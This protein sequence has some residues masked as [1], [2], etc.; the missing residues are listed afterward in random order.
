APQPNLFVDD[1]RAESNGA[2]DPRGPS[3]RDNGLMRCG[4]ATESSQY[5]TSGRIQDAHT[6]DS[7]R[8][9]ALHSGLFPGCDTG[10][11]FPPSAMNFAIRSASTG[12]GTE[13]SARIASWNFRWSNAAP[14]FS[15]AS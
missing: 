2:H 4:P 14:S 15:S 11:L 3:P 10:G 7:E 9:G 8:S 6:H 5:D 1:V 13:P 12:S